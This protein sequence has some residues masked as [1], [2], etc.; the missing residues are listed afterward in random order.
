MAY[1]DLTSIE[2]LIG[3]PS[4]R[5]AASN[6]EIYLRDRLASSLGEASVL[7][8]NLWLW[9]EKQGLPSKGVRSALTHSLINA[10]VNH[11]YLRSW[12]HRVN[13]SFELLEGT[14]GEAD[15]DVPPPSRPVG[16]PLAPPAAP[17]NSAQTEAWL[18]SL[19]AQIDTTV[20]K[21]VEDKLAKTKLT[22]DD[23]AKAQ[24][25][26]IA[27][28]AGEA[29]ATAIC[30]A[31]L[32]PQVIEIHNHVNGTVQSLS[33]QHER[34]PLL[35]RAM[36]ARDHRGFRLNIWLTGPTGSGKTSAAENAAKA[37]SLPF[38]SDGSLDADYT[39]L[40][41]RDANGNIISTEFIRIYA[42]GGIYVADEIDNW[43]P[44]ALLSLNA[45]LANGWMT[46]PGGM[47]RRHKDACVI[48]CANTW[49]LGATGDYVGR[50]RLD[51]ASLDRFQPKIDWPYDEKLELAIASNMDS[52]IGP[53]WFAIVRTARAKAHA[54]G[55]K[56]I[57][58]PRATFNGL[59][60]LAQ[61]FNP[62]E[63]ADMTLAAGISAEQKRAI[64]L[65][66]VPPIAVAHAMGQGRVINDATREL[67]ERLGLSGYAAVLSTLHNKNQQAD[68]IPF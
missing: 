7:K 11:S 44:S 5:G 31:R 68:E 28:G 52:T 36:Q 58:S 30:D 26:A 23:N 4:G 38:G 47:I 62:Q 50:T 37:L 64:G 63:V 32:P 53:A 13:P 16:P 48:A 39:V 55:L 56:I 27:S 51:A 60:L 45:A 43:M 29:M 20:N 66:K 34:F 21:L 8:Q 19:F 3:I 1:M 25:K 6:D 67:N 46:T 2:Q 22:L 42:E 17:N 12:R 41:F 49:G 33:L 61:G 10:Y 35:L 57:I 15:I 9:C 54:Q 24:I 65:D 59:S 14:S 40:G 18:K